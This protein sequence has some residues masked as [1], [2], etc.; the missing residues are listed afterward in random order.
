[1]T[2]SEIC[3]P[4]IDP[5]DTFVVQEYIEG[6]CADLRGAA[7]DAYRTDSISYLYYRLREFFAE[8]QEHWKVPRNPLKLEEFAQRLEEERVK[9][10]KRLQKERP[11]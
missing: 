3:D 11:K 6:F 2:R 4:R 1:M 5:I 10:A 9:K 7:L 8:V